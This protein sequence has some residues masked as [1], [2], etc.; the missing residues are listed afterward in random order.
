M[1]KLEL[2]WAGEPHTLPPTD[3]NGVR[4]ELVEEA[5]PGGGWPLIA[6]YAP[7]GP[8]LWSWLVSEYGVSSDDASDLAS[9]ARDV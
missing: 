2:D 6:V 3:D 7:D 8:T 4:V 1:L 9:L 5:G